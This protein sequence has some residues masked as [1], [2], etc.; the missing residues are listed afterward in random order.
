M[1]LN[2]DVLKTVK[3]A[4]EEGATHIYFAC[5]EFPLCRIDGKVKPFADDA[6]PLD[7]Y[8]LSMIVRSMMP[9]QQLSRLEENCEIEVMLAFPDIGRF[10]LTVFLERGSYAV[11]LEACRKTKTK[12]ES[13]QIPQNLKKMCQNTQGLVLLT[14]LNQETNRQLYTSVYAQIEEDTGRKILVLGDPLTD[15]R[16]SGQLTACRILGT[17]TESYVS[18]L[19]FALCDK[20]DV[21]FIERI[22]DLETANAVLALAFEGTLVIS[23]HY[24]QTASETILSFLEMGVKPSLLANALTGIMSTSVLPKLCKECKKDRE[25]NPEEAKLFGV[26]KRETVMLS[27]P[28]MCKACKNTGFEGEITFTEVLEN[29]SSLRKTITSNPTIDDLQEAVE[30]TGI[31]NIRSLVLKRVKQQQISASEL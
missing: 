17:D 30:R 31:E 12:Q 9:P 3:S 8:D 19:K 5:G 21:V 27:D 10:R 1:S 15:K 28:G 22:M 18:A 7:S 13:L 11:T 23:T 16:K 2:L 14:G 24:T 4:V 20:A 25:A 29:T 6:Y 26:K